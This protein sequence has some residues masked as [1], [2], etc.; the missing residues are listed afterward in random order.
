M[1]NPY[2]EPCCYEK[3]LGILI[4]EMKGNGGSSCFFTN[5]DWNES[6]LLTYLCNRFPQSELFVTFVQVEQ[7]SAEELRKLMNRTTVDRESKRNVPLVSHLY[8]L[9]QGTAYNRKAVYDAL[10]G[11]EEA[12]ITVCE[13]RIGFRSILVKQDEENGCLMQGSLNQFNGDDTQMVNASVNKGVMTCMESVLRG[14][15][16]VKTIK[17]WREAYGDKYL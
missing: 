14:K 1:E 3:W 16:K 13:D 2:I 17:N 5:S 11:V 12:R 10:S 4:E 8:L 7:N 9:M 15:V 6:Q